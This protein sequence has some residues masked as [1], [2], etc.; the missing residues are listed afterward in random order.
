MTETYIADIP[1]ISGVKEKRGFAILL[2]PMITKEE[3]PAG[4]EVWIFPTKV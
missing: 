3:V 2:P 4:T 1:H